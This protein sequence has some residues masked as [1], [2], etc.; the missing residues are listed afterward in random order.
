MNLL[1]TEVETVS[2]AKRKRNDAIPANTDLSGS[3]HAQTSET[4]P[5]RFEEYQVVEE[6]AASQPLTAEVVKVK[7]KKKKAVPAS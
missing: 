1:L 3:M 5:S 4:T 2:A 6:P 7:R